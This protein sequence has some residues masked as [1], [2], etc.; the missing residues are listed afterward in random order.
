MALQLVDEAAFGSGTIDFVGRC[1]TALQRGVVLQLGA[2]EQHGAP[3]RLR[4]PAPF[5]STC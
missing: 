3:E 1:R 4:R 2:V 5:D